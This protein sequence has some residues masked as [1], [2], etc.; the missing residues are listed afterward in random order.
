MK[1][2]SFLLI[3]LVSF[4][5][6]GASI[7]RERINAYTWYT[8]TKN[9]V[10]REEELRMYIVD[11]V[12]GTFSI[13]ITCVVP[14]KTVTVTLTDLLSA[15]VLKQKTYTVPIKFGNRKPVDV[16]WYSWPDGI[17]I[18]RVGDVE[19]TNA[20]RTS[21][22]MSIGSRPNI[23]QFNLANAGRTIG[24]VVQNCRK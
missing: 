1:I 10:T 17:T 24:R 6:A 13:S 16:S 11:D 20:M 8:T 22:H 9:D 12:S 2:V 23:I 7:E 5:N 21:R 14:D 15:P 3:F 4:S 19:F 18:T